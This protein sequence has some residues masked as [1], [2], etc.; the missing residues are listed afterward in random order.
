MEIT[1]KMGDQ[2]DFDFA[3][4]WFASLALT[5]STG[6]SDL[7]TNIKGCVGTTYK[8]GDDLTYDTEPGD[9][10]G[11]TRQAVAAPADGGD[12][13]SLIG[14]DPGAYWDTTMNP[15]YGGINGS[16][17]PSSPRIVAIPL[18]NPDMMAQANSG[19]RTTV[20]IANIMG[21]FVERYDGPCKCVVGRLVT[22][23]GLK[24]S[25]SAPIGGES[26]FLHTVV[27]VR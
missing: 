25:G 21:F 11:P 9:K 22:I 13:D 12:D 1:L 6:G 23:P 2:S 24:A 4:G 20:P 8:I 7:K 5:N 15:P 18:V 26:A 10:V 16:A 14:K 27:L 3:T 19:G 17:F